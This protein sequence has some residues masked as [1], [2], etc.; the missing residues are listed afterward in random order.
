M[1]LGWGRAGRR[2]Y[3]GEVALGTASRVLILLKP[4][5]R[6]ESGGSEVYTPVLTAAPRWTRAR[7]AQWGP[8]RQQDVTQ[9]RKAGGWGWGGF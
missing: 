8:S 3:L 2:W 5:Q 4:G 9:P 6:T 1:S 7:R